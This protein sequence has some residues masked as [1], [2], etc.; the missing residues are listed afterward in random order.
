MTFE[1]ASKKTGDI[2]PSFE[3]LGF[4]MSI[5]LNELECMDIEIPYNDVQLPK[6]A[7]EETLALYFWNVSSSKWERVED[8]TVEPGKNIVWANVTHLTIFAPMATVKGLGEENVEEGGTQYIII[9]IIVVITVVILFGVLLIW[10]KVKTTDTGTNVE[11]EKEG[12]EK[13]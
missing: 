1:E 10:K 3:H 9:L 4:F 8:T 7:D 6:G 11:S 2:G 13:N 5:N 12:N